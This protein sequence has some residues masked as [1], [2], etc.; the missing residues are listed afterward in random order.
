MGCHASIKKDSPLIQKL[1]AFHTEGKRV[2]WAPVY[3]IPD[4]VFFSHKTHLAVG[5][6]T[7]ENCHG[8]VQTRD[9]MRRERDISMAA[10]MDCHRAT[11]ASN[12][13]L[14]CHEQK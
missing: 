12:H 11:N 8:P 3:R 13:C 9:V 5:G 1:A 7:C 14:L 2:P 6:V 10:C 4:Y